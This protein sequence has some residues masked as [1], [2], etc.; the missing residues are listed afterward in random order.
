MGMGGGVKPFF[1]D[2]MK[3]S[4]CS[5]LSDPAKVQRWVRLLGDF[6]FFFFTA[7]PLKLHSRRKGYVGVLGGGGVCV[8]EGGVDGRQLS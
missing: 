2:E 1:A 7:L 5:D 4:C 8:G 3:S 6:F